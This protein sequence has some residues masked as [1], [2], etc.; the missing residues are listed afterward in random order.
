[1]DADSLWPQ[2]RGGLIAIIFR[3][4]AHAR[5][6]AST[7][8]IYCKVLDWTRIDLLVNESRPTVDNIDQHGLGR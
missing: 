1:L 3:D 2:S 8:G 5:R 6:M 4:I 7:W